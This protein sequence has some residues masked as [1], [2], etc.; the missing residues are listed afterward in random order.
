MTGVIKKDLE[1]DY[2]LLLSWRYNSVEFLGLPSLK[3]NRPLTLEEI[4]IPLSFAWEQGSDK[5]VY[6]PEALETSRQLVILGDPGCGKSTLI[7]LVTYSFG[8]T[9]P[10]PLSQR[11]GPLVPVPIILR[12]YHVGSWQSKEDMLDDFIGQLDEDIRDRVSVGWLLRALQE[13][14]GLLL[15]DGLDEVGSSEDR[16]HLRNDIVRPLLSIM[17]ESY[18]ILTSRIVGYEEVPYGHDEVG[19][20]PPLLPRCYVAPFTDEDIDQFITRWYAARE[21]NP[22]RR[23]TGLHSLGQALHQNDRIK[24]LATNPSL[25]TLMVLIHRVTAHLPSGRVKLYDKIVEA[26]LE[27]IQTYRKLGQYPASLD[28]MKRWLARVGWEMQSS[29][30]GAGE[31]ELMVPRDDIVAWLTDAIDVDRVGAAAEA[32]QFLDYVAR[33]SGLLIERKNDVFAFVHL[34]FQEYFAAFHLRGKLGRFDDL[35]STSGFL[36]AQVHWHETLSLLFEMLAEFPGAGDDLLN[37]IE[38]RTKGFPDKRVGAAEFVADLLLD[39]QSGLGLRRQ[40]QAAAYALG[41]ATGSFDEAVLAR[42]KQL[43]A[44]RFEQLVRKWLEKELWRAKP[45]KLGRD[46]FVVGGDLLEDWSRVL[47]EWVTARGELPWSDSQI[48]DIILIAG[49]SPEVHR[50]ATESLPLS[51]WLKARSLSWH[52]YGLANLAELNL[53]TLLEA[54]DE[55]PR[56][57][58]L[59]QFGLASAISGSELIRVSTALAFHQ[60]PDQPVVRA[61]RGIEEILQDRVKRY[62]RM[63]ALDLAMGQASPRDRARVA[64]RGLIVDPYLDEPLV[65]PLFRSLILSSRLQ[66]ASNLELAISSS[67]PKLSEENRKIAALADAECLFF[68]PKTSPKQFNITTRSLKEMTTAQDEWTQLLALS[69]LLMLGAGTPKACGSRNELL[70]K[71]MR[72]PQAFSFP[73]KVRLETDTPA[74]HES[75][76]KLMRMV[77]LHDPDDPWLLPEKLDRSNPESRFFVSSPREFYALAAEVLDPEGKTELAEW[78]NSD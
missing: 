27:T 39:D 13:G 67:K 59:T 78:R 45:E 74:F 47:G 33:R 58:L 63:L 9:E 48:E 14:R 12:D 10:T 43:P 68:S 25:L 50:W 3:E 73:Q 22:E 1:G 70:D 75:L 57:Q 62:A 17:P 54:N 23:R 72:Q 26:Y 46:F 19:I 7:K 53:T 24:R 2:K 56:H 11:F 35:A 55:C 49:E 40:T 5:R 52:H 41:V 18:A 71:A 65:G 69:A 30:V 76:P 37:E 34:T 21:P 60:R 6:L 66:L 28:Q 44:D 29:R 38:E 32:A 4:Y 51:G 36:V 64:S 77:F 31:G 15:L 16:L 20:L 61:L 8:R 42:L